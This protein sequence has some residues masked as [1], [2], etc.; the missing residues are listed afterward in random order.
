M[1]LNSGFGELDGS[2]DEKASILIVDDL[3]EKLLVIETILEELGQHL[4][5][6]R[7][8]GDALRE[9]LRQEFAV[10]LLDV[11]MPGMDG[12][13]TARLIRSYRRSAHTPIIFV[14][15]YADELQTAQGY[16]LGAVDYILSPV[17]PE[18][19]RSKVKVFVELHITQ[20]RLRAQALER[21]ALAAAEAAQRAAEENT[22]RSNFLSHATRMLAGS[23]EADVGMRRL[24][25][26]VVPEMAGQAG[27]RLFADEQ[28]PD[29]L[30]CCTAAE[31]PPALLDEPGEPR[32]FGEQEMA[33]LPE[34][35]QAV[36]GELEQF[37]GGDAQAAALLSARFTVGAHTVLPILSGNLPLGALVIARPRPGLDWSLLEELANRA[38]MAFENARLYRNL[39]IEIVERRQAQA[40][41]LE[42]NQRKDEF[43]AMLSHELR[44]PLAPIR[45][46]VEV[47]RRL[48][49]EADA[50][51]A[52]AT[53]VTE[54]QLR[55]LSR[56]VDELLDVARISQGKIALRV[57]TVD[58]CAVVAQGVETV[59]DLIDK[60]R[61]ELQLSLPAQPVWLQGD[62]ARLAQVVA[63]LLHNA[64]KY[65]EEGGRIE[66][67]L[68][69][70]GGEAQ[71]IVRDNGLGID[72]ELLP[73]VFD[74]FEQG[75]RALDRNQGG[76]GVG[77]TLVQRLVELHQGRV[78]A[79]SAGS[80][81]GAEFRVMLPA[82]VEARP[83]AL[84]PTQAPA[85][86]AP[87][88]VAAAAC[89]VLVV[90]DNPDIAE[91]I[92][93]YLELTGHQVRAVGDG[94]QAQACAAEF[95]PQVVVLDIGLPQI[96]GYEVARRLRALPATADS[97]LIALTGYGQAA[98]R[99]KA[100]QAG[101]GAHMV[102]PAD[103]ERL[104]RLI[105][106]WQLAD[107]SLPQP[108]QLMDD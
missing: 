48:T 84:P 51:V 73:H 55:Q 80:G 66:L 28:P 59:R 23:L 3:P 89:R 32:E 70:V 7:S 104:A 85:A 101:F 10:I 38:A 16:S 17:V 67:L 53:D 11:N 92:A 33:E 62:F 82:T 61:H 76:L 49:P 108:L 57:E 29:R 41:L 5:V 40:R 75:K 106:D 39:Q 52:W 6:V 58:L 90:D 24:L 87:V 21:I 26:L 50:R 64:A 69:V 86:P 103:P 105:A 25:E 65:T 2:A 47:I 91:T 56:L 77:L 20:R 71:L 9:V 99:L 18:V 34:L 88:P 42:A 36:L 79:A 93:S 98:D 46:A 54:R 19:L 94:M 60:R 1:P 22:R 37:A 107:R 83:A 13:E 35:V 4:V 81:Q 12:L 97:L 31:P 74:L 68:S 63:N 8:G 44:N 43:L 100:R 14:T 96:D 45:N 78:S 95:A 15:A 27:L 72:A 102:K 30:L